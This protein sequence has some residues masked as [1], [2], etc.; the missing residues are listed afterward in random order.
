[1][2]VT[3]FR[4]FVSYCHADARFAAR[5]QR[6]LEN[7]RLPKRLLGQVPPWPGERADRIGPVFRDREDL[8]AAQD[9]SEAVRQA[10]AASDALI[11]VASPPA[12]Q[13]HWVSREIELFRALHPDRLILV[14]L[15]EGEP[16]AAMPPALLAAGSEP[17]AADFREV[18]DGKRLA[19]LKIVAGLCN[20][21]LDALVQRD[22]QRRLTRV[23]AVTLAAL[24]IAL[25][26]AAITAFALA[27]RAQ[28][29]RERNQAEGLVEFMLTDLRDRLRTVGRL[30]V[31]ERVNDRAMAYYTAQ[32]DLAAL[33]EPSLLRRTRILQAMG[34]DDSTAGRDSTALAKF[35]EAHRVTEQLLVRRPNDPDR[36]FAHAQSEYWVGYAAWET[37]DVAAARVDF[38]RYAT[39]ADRL[40]ASDANNK[41]WQ[42]EAGYAASNLGTLALKGEKRPEKALP[43]FKSSIA[44]FE[45]ALR[46]APG[47]PGMMRDLADAYAW[48][49]DTLKQ[50]GKPEAALVERHKEREIYLALVSRDMR[51]AKL[52]LDLIGSSAGI[53]RLELMLGQIE[54]AVAHFRSAQAAIGALV[55]R[56]PE[57]QEIAKEKMRISLHLAAALVRLPE[58]QPADR[59]FVN[60]MR[61]RC[62]SITPQQ[63]PDARQ[64]CETLRNVKR[65][66]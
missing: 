1:M 51:N 63:I 8:S 65:R 45:A 15:I 2:S 50:L 19:F 66:P 13:S 36:I 23:M 12:A 16:A 26:M 46:L 64:L 22:A 32:G 44:R 55:E 58:L 43:L 31:M 17:L 33:P 9:L 27:S 40:V 59:L 5:L 49:A 29:V 4:A 42:M 10:L 34:E 6:R 48:L 20:L 24:A 30:D 62:A 39:L 37:G 56:D 52:T 35:R 53:A 18:G 41:T 61:Q 11:V 57:N 60:A 21:P 25:S 28:A 54:P 47:N 38:E 14:A 7:Y 3:P